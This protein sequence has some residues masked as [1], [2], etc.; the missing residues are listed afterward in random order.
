M[1]LGIDEDN[2]WGQEEILISPGDMLLMYTDGV[3]DA[4]NNNGEF[5]DR[6][7]ILNAA[8]KKNGKSVQDVMDGILESVHRFVGEAPRFDDITMVILGRENDKN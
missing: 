1:P 2:N 6:K 7:I 3:T 8:K 4:Q 5:I